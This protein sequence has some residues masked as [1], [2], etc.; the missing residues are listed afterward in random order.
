MLTTSDT[1]EKAVAGTISG[2]IGLGET[3]T[4]EARH[5]GIKQR[6]T[7]KITRFERPGLFT[8]EMMEGAFK[9]IRHDHIFKEEKGITCMTDHFIFESPYGIAGT[10]F[11]FLILKR[12]LKKLL[13]NRNCLIK[14]YAESEKWRQILK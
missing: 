2:L 11:N 13:I 7:S 8:D 5:F 6:L 1:E 3:V 10:F 9:M 14:E 12:Y 4:W